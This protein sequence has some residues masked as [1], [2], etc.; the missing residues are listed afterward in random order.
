MGQTYSSFIELPVVGSL[1]G[2][3][4][5]N[6]SIKG[7]RLYQN[8]PNPFNSATDISFSLDKPAYVELKVYNTRGKKVATILNRNMSAGTHNVNFDISHRRFLGSEYFYEMKIGDTIKRMKM[9]L[10]K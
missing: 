4:F 9:V 2:I 10:L 6:D 5:V 8:H 3:A 1:S 7:F